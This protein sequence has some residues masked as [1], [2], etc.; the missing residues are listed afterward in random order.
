MITF[1][2]ETFK[3]DMLSSFKGTKLFT[4]TNTSKICNQKSITQISFFHFNIRLLIIGNGFGINRIY[5]DRSADNRKL[6][7]KISTNMIVIYRSWFSND[8]DGI[9]LFFINKSQDRCNE[10]I[11][12][13]R[14][15]WKREIKENI[16]IK[17]N[18]TD[19]IIFGWNINTYKESVH[20]ITTFQKR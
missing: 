9:E 13:I 14:V 12:S 3:S 20:G 16:L 19:L 17:V 18:S 6:R 5:D 2:S 8:D 15:I 10:K 11:T 1:T 4:A 7:W